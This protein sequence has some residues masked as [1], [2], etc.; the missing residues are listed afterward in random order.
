MTKD[1]TRHCRIASKEVLVIYL[2]GRH[3]DTEARAGRD[4]SESVLPLKMWPNLQLQATLV[5]SRKHH[6]SLVGSMGTKGGGHKDIRCCPKLL[7]II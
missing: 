1:S 7:G 3:I 5:K 6:D 4:P 2:N